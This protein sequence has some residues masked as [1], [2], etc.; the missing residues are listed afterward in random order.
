MR[1]S[2]YQSCMKTGARRAN[3][4]QTAVRRPKHHAIQVDIVGFDDDSDICADWWSLCV[5]LASHLR[6][7][8]ACQYGACC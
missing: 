6:T 8:Q 3:F 1:P 5:L 4:L 7:V 2:V